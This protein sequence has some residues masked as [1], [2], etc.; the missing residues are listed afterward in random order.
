VTT[1]DGE[2]TRRRRRGPALD[3]AL[4]D[5]AWEEL[6]EVGFAKLTME[7]VAL[8]AGT[9][10]A[11]L[12]R[13]WANKDQLT[14]AALEHHRSTHPVALPDTGTLRGDLLGALTAMGQAGAAFF[15]VT[16]AAAFSGLLAGAGLTPAQ[17][18][19]RI[20]GDQ[21]LPR[22]Q[23]IYQRAHDRGEIDLDRIAFAVLAMPFDLVRH[24]LLMNVEP[25][26]TARIRS[27]VDDLF[28]P[29]VR[30]HRRGHGGAPSPDDGPI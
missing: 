23:A 7:S 30:E 27:I 29:L 12:Y 1:T 6:I 2:P 17:V 4:L 25:A 8:R 10:V 20:I 5:A 22:V 11:V 19:D 21:R 16:A 26:K 28:L 24:D 9:G 14:L 13:R 3:A 18:R 15:A